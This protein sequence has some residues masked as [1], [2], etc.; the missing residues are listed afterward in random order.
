MLLIVGAISYV[1]AQEI[2]ALEQGPRLV[3]PVYHWS[4]GVKGGANFFRVGGYPYN[5]GSSFFQKGRFNLTSVAGGTIEYTFNPV[6]GLGV[7]GTY[8]GFSHALDINTDGLKDNYL[9]GGTTDALLYAS[10]NLSNMMVP[11]RIGFWSFV[12]LYAN[13]GGGLSL[14]HYKVGAHSTHGDRAAA[15]GM[16]GFNL[17]FNMSKSLSLGF[18]GQYRYYNQKRMGYYENVSPK[19]YADAAVTTIGLRYKFGGN[20]EVKKHVR[21]ITKNEYVPLDE[22]ND[23]IIDLLDKCANT[24]AEVVVDADGCPVDTDGDGVADYLDK[25]PGTVVAAYGKV[26]VN[27]CPLD[28]D[29]DGVFD[30]LDKCPGTPIEAR[31]YTDLS[32]CPLDVD[33]DGVADYMDKCVNTPVEAK[34]YVDNQGCPLDTDGDGIFDYL[35]DCPKLAGVIGSKGC[36]EVKKE[37]KTLFQKALQGIQFKTGKADIKPTSYALLNQ[38]AN[39]LILNPT[40]LI[41]VQGHTDDVGTS[42]SNLILSESRAM[43]VRNYLV[44]KGV[45]EQTITSKGYGEDKPIADN[46]TKAG[47]AQNRRVEFVVTFEK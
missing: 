11:N 9:F 24:P 34:G 46:A 14:Y 16:G 43:A 36:P 20:D 15:V 5:S 22:D 31:G 45:N 47:K 40:Y 28:T 38:I 25:C 12:N 32:G 3:V 19:G 30:Y 21:N 29:G 17:E 42:E 6:F 41:E 18:E 33:G 44:S 7:E 8:N 37:V 27:G 35:D 1:P 10:F 26:D 13:A 4:L 23:G 2:N 39:T